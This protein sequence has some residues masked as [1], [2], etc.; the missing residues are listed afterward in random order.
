MFFA[1]RNYLSKMSVT[2]CNKKNQQ[3]KTQ[4]QVY[5]KLNLKQ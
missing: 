3:N 1:F 2:S 5:E 4:F